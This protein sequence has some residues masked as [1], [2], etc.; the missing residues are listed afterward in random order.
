MLG[1]KEITNL[2]HSTLSEKILE[3]TEKEGN[4]FG[5]EATFRDVI[6]RIL[7]IIGEPIE[8]LLKQV[9]VDFKSDFY[10]EQCENSSELVEHACN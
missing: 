6:D 9:N 3:K 7:G 1:N 2:L 10:S 5:S 8:N 4:N